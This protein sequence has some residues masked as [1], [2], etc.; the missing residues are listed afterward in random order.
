MLRTLADKWWVLLINGLCAIVF[1][2]LAYA[3]PA[4]TLV[5]LVTLFGVFCIVDGVTALMAA[6]A[7]DGDRR[8][9]GQLQ[10]IGI[11]SIAAGVAALAWPGLTT[12]ALVFVIA[13]WAIVRGVFE[14]V[15]AVRLRR[16]INN[17]WLLGVAGAVSVLFG[18]ALIAAPGAGALA[19]VWLIAAFAA[20][21]GVLLVVLAFKL[22]GRRQARLWSKA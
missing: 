6:G 3:W 10:L 8:A 12:V 16:F 7:R 21:H 18:V 2:V 17:E 9:W 22:R 15:A 14:I 20:V 5:V 1:G 4:A 11:V 19:L 13:A